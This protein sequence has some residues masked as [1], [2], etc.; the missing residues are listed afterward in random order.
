MIGV[1]ITCLWFGIRLRNGDLEQ[2]N[3]C[4]ICRHRNQE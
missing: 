1:T 4:V 2:L 3:Q